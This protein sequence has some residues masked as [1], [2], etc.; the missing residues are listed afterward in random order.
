MRS[1]VDTTAAAGDGGGDGRAARGAEPELARG[2]KVC[3]FIADAPPHGLGESGDGFPNG[4][5]DGHDQSSSSV[6]AVGVEPT[7]STS[8]KFA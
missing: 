1:N 8:Y 7:L 4:S 2:G 3:V 5:P 6:Y